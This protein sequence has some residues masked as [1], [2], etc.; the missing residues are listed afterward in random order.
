MQ[1]LSAEKRAAIKDAIARAEKG[2]SGEIIVVV[3]SASARYFAIG[4]MWAELVALSVPLPL[5]WFTDWPVE[6]IYI[7][8]FAVFVLGSR[9]DP[10]GTASFCPRAEIGKA[11]RGT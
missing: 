9:T 10:V 4:V 11:R 3:T 5:I 8:Q 6:H 2:T 1:H 7:A